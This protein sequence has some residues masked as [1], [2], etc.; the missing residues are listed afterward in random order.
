MYASTVARWERAVAKL[1][2]GVE[3]PSEYWESEG[4]RYVKIVDKRKRIECTRGWSFEGA[5]GSG[6]GLEGE[7]APEVR[8]RKF[9]GSVDADGGYRLLENIA[10]R[11]KRM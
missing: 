6:P 10:K 5:W 9:G 1:R 11:V 7:V 8:K 4:W 2:K 3:M